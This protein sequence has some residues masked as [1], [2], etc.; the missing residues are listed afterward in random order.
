MQ[1][2]VNDN[3]CASYAI[4]DVVF[5]HKDNTYPTKDCVY[6]FIVDNENYKKIIDA[7][8]RQNTLKLTPI[9]K[10]SNETGYNYRNA[11]VVIKKIALIDIFTNTSL[12]RHCDLTFDTYI[13]NPEDKKDTLI[14]TVSENISISSENH[15][16]TTNL[17]E[18]RE[19]KM[20]NNIMKDVK[21]GKVN[22]VKMSIYGPAFVGE[23]D[24]EWYSF[25]KKS[26]EYIDVSDMLLNVDN[27]CWMMP[28][29]K[30]EVCVNDFI[31]HNGGW[32][33]VID[34]DDSLRLVVEKLRTKEVVTVLPTKNM[35]GFDF[36]TKLVSFSEG[37]FGTMSNEPSKDNPF[38]G[39]LPLLMMSDSKDFNEM[40]PLMF[41]M[42]NQGKNDFNMNS[43]QMMM[44][45]MMNANSSS[46]NKMLEYMLMM[47]MMNK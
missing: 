6:Q 46:D 47:N 32:V 31:W 9:Y 1:K 37:L 4:I 42:N 30:S 16:N 43:N 36:Y 22:S 40:I 21:F 27:F 39:M 34:F 38:G 45:M 10:I 11:S 35:F 24:T 2:K 20:F 17:I 23:R 7:S 12:F 19:N 18:E 29:S 41:M 26:Q 3:Y 25:D 28:V 5:L 14:P 33:R 13:E 44:L 15:S 8:Y